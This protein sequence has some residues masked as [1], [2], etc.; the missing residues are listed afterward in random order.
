MNDTFKL[1]DLPIFI[2]RLKG[3]LIMK[4]NLYGKSIVFG[5]VLLFIGASV[6]STIADSFDEKNI[7]VF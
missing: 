3:R 5:I 6:V 2:L 7:I 1:N 4:N